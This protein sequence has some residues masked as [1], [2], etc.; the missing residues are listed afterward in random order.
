MAAFRSSPKAVAFAMTPSQTTGGGA[1]VFVLL[2]SPSANRSAMGGVE[3]LEWFDANVVSS[4]YSQ[5]RIP[6]CRD[7]FRLCRCAVP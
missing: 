7:Y 4:L 6:I 5:T 3:L 1:H 2:S